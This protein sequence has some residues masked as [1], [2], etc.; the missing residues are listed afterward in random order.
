M[1]RAIAT[2]QS[3][4]RHAV[5][6]GLIYKLHYN[7]LQVLLMGLDIAKMK[8]LLSLQKGGKQE[9]EVTEL[10]GAEAVKWLRGN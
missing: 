10:S 5:P 1:P 9:K 3:C 4:V 2:L 6:D 7:D 8:E